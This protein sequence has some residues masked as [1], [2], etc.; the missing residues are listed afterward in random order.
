MMGMNNVQAT[1][2]ACRALHLCPWSWEL[3]T[4]A[5]T[6]AATLRPE[7]P[8][9]AARLCGSIAGGCLH[10][11]PCGY[12]TG[13]TGKQSS[14]PSHETLAS[15]CS[16]DD[17]MSRHPDQNAEASSIPLQ[18]QRHCMQSGTATMESL[19]CLLYCL[20]SR[21]PLIDCPHEGDCRQ[22]L[23]GVCMQVCQRG[24]FSMHAACACRHMRK[25][26]HVVMCGAGCMMTQEQLTESGGLS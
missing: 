21:W 25:L 11:L 12:D 10:L 18:M 9:H 13:S 8:Q 2:D 23:I 22:S 20:C 7:A 1:R 16:A 24:A 17:G 4:Q 19:S 5:A 26:Q 3:R 14:P 6:S 15:R